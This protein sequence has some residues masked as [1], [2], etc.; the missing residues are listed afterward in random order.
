MKIARR[1]KQ[2][3]IGAI[4]ATAMTDKRNF[5]ELGECGNTVLKLLFDRGKTVLGTKA[6][7]RG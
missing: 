5:G 2:E 1:E 3:T 6:R 4:L 7:C